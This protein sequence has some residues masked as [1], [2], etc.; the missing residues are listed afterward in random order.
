MYSYR[1][2]LFLILANSADPDEM[3]HYAAF[4]LGRHCLQMYRFISIQKEKRYS[5]LVKSAY[6]KKNSY[7]STKTYVVGT[8]KNRLNET[9]LLS[10]QNIC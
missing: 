8:Q 2:R 5:P 6:Q 3:L 1:W 10:T 7:F 4:N 9:V